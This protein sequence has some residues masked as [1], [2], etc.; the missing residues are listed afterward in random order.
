MGRQL[1]HALR[2]SGISPGHSTVVTGSALNEKSPRAGTTVADETRGEMEASSAF[3]VQDEQES[4][5]NQ[6]RRPQT[7]GP[8]LWGRG[9]T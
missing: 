6:R 3:A 7:P 4:E 5:D 2:P 9:H 1:G 8:A